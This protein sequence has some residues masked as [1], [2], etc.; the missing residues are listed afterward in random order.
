MKPKFDKKLKEILMTDPTGDGTKLGLGLTS[1][2]DKPECDQVQVD[3]EIVKGKE[4]D[5]NEL[6]EAEK[7]DEDMEED[8]SST[9]VSK[10]A[11]KKN[12]KVPLH[13]LSQRKLRKMQL[14]QKNKK[15]K[16]LKW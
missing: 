16:V 2:V 15:N 3:A 4:V 5:S 12:A 1:N 9:I 6:K 7:V 8:D 11:S 14:K 13:L 10:K